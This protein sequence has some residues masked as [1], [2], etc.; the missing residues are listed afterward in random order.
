MKLF[1]D[2]EKC[3][4]HIVDFNKNLNGVRESK[5]MSKATHVLAIFLIIRVCVSVFYKIDFDSI[6]DR[7]IELIENMFTILVSFVTLYISIH[8][9]KRRDFLTARKNA[10]MLSEILES[11]YYQIENISR[12]NLTIISYPQTWIDYY[13]QC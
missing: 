6:D 4:D 1:K 2:K 12:G 7:C 13:N 5:P 11:V 10:Y 3:I 9:D 8:N